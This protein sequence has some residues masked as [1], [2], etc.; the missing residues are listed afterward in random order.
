MNAPEKGLF[1]DKEANKIELYEMTILFTRK[2]K[3]LRRISIKKG[4]K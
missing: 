4:K 3:F 1:Y 2:S